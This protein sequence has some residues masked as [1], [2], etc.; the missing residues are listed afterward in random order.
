MNRF[1]KSEPTLQDVIAPLNTRLVKSS[2]G[3]LELRIHSSNK[4]IDTSIPTSFSYEGVDVILAF[5]DL[6]FIANRVFII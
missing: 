4:S 1:L 5:G 6:S 3:S 2:N